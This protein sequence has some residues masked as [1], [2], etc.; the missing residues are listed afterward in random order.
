MDRYIDGYI[1]ILG[2]QH[3]EASEGIADNA[4]YGSGLRSDLE[5]MCKF[6]KNL[7]C[8]KLQII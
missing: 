1:D 7:Y 3:F 8:S 2:I 6:K 4:K 5:M